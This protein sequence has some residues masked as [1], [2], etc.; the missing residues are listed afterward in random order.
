LN[1]WPGG[2]FHFN[3]ASAILNESRC[4]RVLCNFSEFGM[5]YF[6]GSRRHENK[7]VTRGHTLLID[8][9]DCWSYIDAGKTTEL[10]HLFLSLSPLFLSVSLF[11]GSKYALKITTVPSLSPCLCRRH[12]RALLFSSV[13]ITIIYGIPRFAQCSFKAR[14]RRRGGRNSTHPSSGDRALVGQ[15]SHFQDV[16]I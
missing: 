11:L 3:S 12:Q 1:L 5:G 6:C 7:S 13:A 16:Q 8:Y 15:G 2:G 9:K 10:K 14:R 4:F